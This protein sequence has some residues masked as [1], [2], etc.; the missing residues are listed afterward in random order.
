MLRSDNIETGSEFQPGEWLML[1]YTRTT[2]K[3]VVVFSPQ[4]QTGDVDKRLTLLQ[5]WIDLLSEA[6][7]S[8]LDNLPSEPVQ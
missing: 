7:D 5:A 6:Y 4:W 8:L 1:G 2:D 3:P